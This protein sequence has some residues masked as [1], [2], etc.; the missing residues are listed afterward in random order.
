MQHSAL[1][2]RPR[3]GH[4]TSLFQIR[5]PAFWFFVVLLILTGLITLLEQTA[6]LVEAPG[7]WL[8]SW[9]LLALYGVP[10]FLLVYFLDLYEREPLSLVFG[11]FLWGGVVATA[12]AGIGNVGWGLVVLVA[13]GG[14]FA[15]KWSAALTAPFVEE[16]LKGASVVMIYLI[17][18]REVDD[19]MDGFVYGAMAG[20]G[21]AVVEDVFY[22]IVRFGGS[23]EAVLVGFFVRVIASGLYSHVLWSGLVG[24]GVGFF[25]GRK[26]EASPARRLW[27]AL[28][29]F[30][31][32]VVGHFLWNSPLLDLFPRRLSAGVALL[33]IVGAAAV[34]GLPLLAGVGVMVVLARRREHRWLRAA[35]VSEMGG[36]GILEEEMAVLA[37]PR[38]RR[39]ARRELRRRAGPGA[40]AM[41]KRFHK[42]QVNLAMIATRAPGDDHPD[43]L[44]QRRYC[45]A[46]REALVVSM[47]P[48]PPPPPTGT[49]ASA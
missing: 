6:F 21:F 30:A 10:I 7:G 47:S 4:Q 45:R 1:P 32:A 31:A 34:K 17:A 35:L 38:R 37:N 18:R 49:T 11:A 12:L 48:L 27:V 5:Q 36:E 25:V 26:G 22:F 9:F 19:T 41:L 2:R 23:A 42:A 29:L 33:Q 43:L 39:R 46:L 16:I 15:A 20:L 28:G 8:L 44:N 13:G 40:A 24:I 3:W 14:E